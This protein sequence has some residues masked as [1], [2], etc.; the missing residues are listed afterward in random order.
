MEKQDQQIIKD[1]I[2]NTEE[3]V[4]EKQPEGDKDWMELF[5]KEAFENIK[6]PVIFG[7][8]N[9]SGISDPSDS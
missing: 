1:L 3:H 5:I 7:F 4:S 8:S 9:Y 2:I 6:A